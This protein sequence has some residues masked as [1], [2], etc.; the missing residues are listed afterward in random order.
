MISVPTYEISSAH[1][2]SDRYSIT[3]LNQRGKLSAVIEAVV[4]VDV[5]DISISILTS[6]NREAPPKN[7][8]SHFVERMVSLRAGVEVCV[9]LYRDAGGEGSGSVY[10]ATLLGVWACGPEIP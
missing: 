5:N 1:S 9:S 10:V 2:T 8:P 3:A 4:V 6:K 7:E